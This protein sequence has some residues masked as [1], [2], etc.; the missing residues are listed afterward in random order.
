[1]SLTDISNMEDQFDADDQSESEL[2]TF[3]R[4]VKIEIGDMTYV[5]EPL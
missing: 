5:S 3:G 1:M 2:F 4:K